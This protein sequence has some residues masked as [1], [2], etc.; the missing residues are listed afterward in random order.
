MSNKEAIEITFHPQR[1][2]FEGFSSADFV[3]K[4]SLSSASAYPQAS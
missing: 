4:F 3:L 1:E 2:R